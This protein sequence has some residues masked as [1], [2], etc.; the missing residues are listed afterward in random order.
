MPPEAW[1]RQRLARYSALPPETYGDSDRDVHGRPVATVADTGCAVDGCRKPVVH[2]DCLGARPCC[3]HV[4]CCPTP[5]WWRRAAWIRAAWK[6]T[7]G[8]G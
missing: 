2:E 6:G 5:P 7:D 1:H 4:V 3:P 8:A